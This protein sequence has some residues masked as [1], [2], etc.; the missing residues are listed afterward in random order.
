MV[1]EGAQLGRDALHV[2]QQRQQH[3]LIRVLLLP[4]T[5]LLLLLLALCLRLPFLLL[6]QGHRCRPANGLGLLLLVQLI[7]LPLLLRRICI[8]LLRLL[9]PTAPANEGKG[10]NTLSLTATTAG[11][12][13]DASRAP[14]TLTTTCLPLSNDVAEAPRVAGA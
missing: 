11:W 9:L 5:L 6:L 4:L 12:Q 1:P 3:R 14:Q 8:L 2:W 13:A 7:R 10:G